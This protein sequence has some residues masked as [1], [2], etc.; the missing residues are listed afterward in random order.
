[1]TNHGEIVVR[2][3]HDGILRLRRYLAGAGAH[4]AGMQR[5]VP[6]SQDRRHAR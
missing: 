4:R 1:M 3:R 6:G 5:E 2:R